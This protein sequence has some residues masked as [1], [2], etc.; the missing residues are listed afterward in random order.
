MKYLKSLSKSQNITIICAF[1]LSILIYMTMPY[2]P[3][4]S[5]DSIG[6]LKAASGLLN[7]QG[8]S[9]FT[10]QWPPL[11][12]LMISAVSKIFNNDILKGAQVL[13][14]ILYG[15]IFIVTTH[16]I[17]KTTKN[18]KYFVLAISL[19]ICLQG[20]ITYIQYYTWSEA[21]FIN[22][23]LINIAILIKY[24]ESQKNTNYIFL[25]LIFISI[26]LCYTR[27]IGY[28]IA[29]SNGLLILLLN[30]DAISKKIIKFFI[31]IFIP[32]FSILPWLSYRSTFE[33]ANTSASFK[34]QGFDIEKFKIG[35][36]NIGRWLMR[37]NIGSD[38]DG[39]A[40]IYQ[41]GG[42]VI[43]SF[44][45]LI[46]I[47]NLDNFINRKTKSLDEKSKTLYLF[48]IS[49]TILTYLASF[50]FFILFLT[51]RITF[52][53]RYLVIIYIP[54]L[55]IILIT[56]DGIK[57]NF[58]KYGL[59]TILIIC[60]LFSMPETKQRMLV[61]YFNGIELNS[62]FQRQKQIY[63][64]INSCSKDL[65]VVA[66]FPWHYDLIFSNKV[67]W[68]PRE[69]Y[70]GSNSKNLKFRSEIEDLKENYDLII[71]ENPENIA[72]SLIN[73]EFFHLVFEGNGKV[74]ANSKKLTH[75][76]GE[77]R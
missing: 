63:K 55:I 44:I 15:M 48:T 59:K 14:S 10:S 13:Q 32:L 46:S 26:L 60:L 28:S 12:P 27:Y 18:N 29:I 8:I 22:L 74:W 4:L 33:N 54:T 72:I 5:P 64:F 57:S 9:Y 42:V 69:I 6:Y 47:K 66:D 3:G 36:A 17:M 20:L 21:L 7:G 30:K 61:S 56:I 68:L 43:L 77:K 35:L 38:T 45:I 73:T 41:I 49:I 19:L 67:T 2:G 16:L 50:T 23:V 58:V 31:L 34:F 11:Y 75:G 37:N 52:E 24:F 51:A 76:C 1:L 39:G 71:I 25:S 62:N 70:Y 65:K 40:I 53:N